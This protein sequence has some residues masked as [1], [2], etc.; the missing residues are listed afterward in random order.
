MFLVPSPVRRGSKRSD[1][2]VQSLTNMVASIPV[3]AD[4]AEMDETG[5]RE[6]PTGAV[7]TL[8]R[9]GNDD[10]TRPF[11]EMQSGMS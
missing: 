6:R 11:M 3:G 7:F 8:V 2:P 1:R 10:S 5:E 9:I 4:P